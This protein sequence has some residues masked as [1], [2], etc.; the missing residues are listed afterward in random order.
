[1]VWRAE[2]NWIVDAVHPQHDLAVLLGGT[3]VDTAVAMEVALIVLTNQHYIAYAKA[4]P[5]VENPCG[6]LQSLNAEM[7][8]RVST[9][10]AGNH[11]LIGH[12]VE[13]CLRALRLSMR[14]WR[15]IC[16][17]ILCHYLTG[18][19]ACPANHSRTRYSISSSCP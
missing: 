7:E 14:P 3:D 9:P 8:Q 4:Q 19:M 2:K 10:V 18:S 1:M 13:T 15:V 6:P 16:R 11:V 12:A 5:V 17:S